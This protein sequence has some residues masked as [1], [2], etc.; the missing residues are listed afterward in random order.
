MTIRVTLTIGA[1]ATALLSGCAAS[2][3]ASGRFLVQPDRYQLYNC[4][5]LAEAAQ[6][7]AARERELEGLMTKAG[8]DASGRFV[9]TVAY[10]PEY[11]LLHG[12]MNELRKT[13]AEKKCKFNP[14]APPGARVS[15]QAIR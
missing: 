9:S 12:Q 15:D 8:P 10:R 7:I 2:D 11:L 13:A 14:D 5:E 1:L 6:S 3:D 4:R